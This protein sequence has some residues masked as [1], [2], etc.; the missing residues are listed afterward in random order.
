MT[1]IIILLLAAFVVIVAGASM[2]RKNAREKKTETNVGRTLQSDVLS[3]VSPPPSRT[4]SPTYVEPA[5]EPAIIVV[6]D[7]I[8]R[9]E[10]KSE[11]KR[12]S[13]IVKG[14]LIQT[15]LACDT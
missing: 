4:E 3:E 12:M 7:E 6:E 2:R 5:V 11:K 9:R 8:I 14:G 13:R 15:S 1:P 10:P